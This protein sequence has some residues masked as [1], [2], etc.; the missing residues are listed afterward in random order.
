MLSQLIQRV[1]PAS[2]KLAS[3]SVQNAALLA[4]GDPRF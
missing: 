2:T 4:P 1:S 3:A